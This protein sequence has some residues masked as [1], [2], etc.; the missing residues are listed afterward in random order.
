MEY[1]Q[2]GVAGRGL[3]GLGV[4]GGPGAAPSPTLAARLEAAAHIINQ[5]CARIEDTLARVNGTPRANQVQAEK[6]A[7][8]AT[9]PLA[10]SVE[11]VEQ[12][13]KRLCELSSALS[14]VA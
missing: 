13:A 11:M 4:I 14:Q 6:Q 9:A 5:Q 12:Q 3:S 1:A 2:Q 10:Q 8:Q 7:I